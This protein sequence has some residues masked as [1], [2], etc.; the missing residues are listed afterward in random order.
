L[1]KARRYYDGNVDEA[2]DLILCT[3]G[4]T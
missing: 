4:C 3:P 2:L 1:P